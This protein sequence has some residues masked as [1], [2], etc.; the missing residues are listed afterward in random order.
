MGITTRATRFVQ[1][2]T[3]A[4]DRGPITIRTLGDG[5]NAAGAV[6]GVRVVRR[7]HRSYGER[8]GMRATGADPTAAKA[9]I[10]IIGAVENS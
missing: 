6:A 10:R 3:A 7:Q 5:T 4:D 2:T 8:A 9:G 1:R